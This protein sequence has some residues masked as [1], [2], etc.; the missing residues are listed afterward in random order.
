MLS[1]FMSLE[2]AIRSAT[3]ER[4]GIE[5]TPNDDQMANMIFVSNNIFD[6]IREFVQSQLTCSSFLRVPELNRILGSSDRSF[7]TFGAAIDLKRIGSSY[8][9]KQIFDFIRNELMFSELI[10]E[11]GTED[12]PA[13]VHVAYLPGDERKMVKRAIRLES[14]RSKIVPFDLY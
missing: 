14:G 2:E 7:H 4:H 12:E 6:C 3:A 5:N 13:W 9:Y 1:Q 10:W 11:F 8:T